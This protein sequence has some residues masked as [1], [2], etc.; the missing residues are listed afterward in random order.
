M[1]VNIKATNI[2]LTPE[3]RDSV[4]K[5]C[6]AIAKIAG[7]DE[8][9]MLCDAE[10]GKSTKHHQ[11]GPFFRAEINF[12]TGGKYVRAEA[13]REYLQTAL[14][15]ARDELKRTIAKQKHKETSL[16]RRTGA[17]IKNLLRFGR[18]S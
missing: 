5:T 14:D 2:T 12:S 10:V 7:G 9:M 11:T 16:L 8:S 13:E 15:E 3:I 17:R 4:E 18:G 1:K 6:N